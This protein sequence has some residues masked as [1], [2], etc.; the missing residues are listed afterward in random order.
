MTKVLSEVI[1]QRMLA[2]TKAALHG[3]IP[4]EH[5]FIN[6]GEMEWNELF[7]QLC[8][9][10]VMALSFDGAMRLPKELQPP[11]SVKLRW[12][13]SVEAVEKRYRRLRETAEKLFVYFRENNIKMLLFKGIALSRFYPTPARREFGDIDIFLCGKQEE[14]NALLERI[15][16]KKPHFSKKHTNFHY[17]G[18]LIE[19]HHTLLSH[20]EYFKIFR[21][22]KVL[23]KRL[24][25]ILNETGVM[26]ET[27]F[28]GSGRTDETMLFPSPDFD[29]L[30]LTLHLLVHFSNKIV[31][32][33][34]C[35]LTILFTACKGEIDFA[36]YRNVLSEAGLLKLSDAFISLLVRYLGLNPEYAPP[37]K[38]DLS[39]ENKIWNDMLNPK[40]PL[41]YWKN[42]LV[43][44]GQ[45]IKINLYLKARRLIYSK[46]IRKLLKT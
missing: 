45:F 19:N 36:A 38:C 37:Y 10:G 39:L 3:T 22:S 7:E 32:R 12:I 46:F 30:F 11:L 26:D 41:S 35:D 6:I 16:D 1:S 2:L 29:A 18:I 24:M 27:F 25:M 8:A 17:N 28:A 14:G 43:F 40:I 4:D 23:E 15:A 13:A 20:N 42:E 34:L 5:L 31:L 21:Y 33:Q 44:P 9:Q